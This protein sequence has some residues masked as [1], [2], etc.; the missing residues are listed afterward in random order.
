MVERTD[1]Q[2]KFLLKMALDNSVIASFQRGDIYHGAEGREDVGRELRER[3]RVFGAKYH[4]KVSDSKH[5]DNIA[6]L[7]TAMTERFAEDEFLFEG[8]FRIG[9]AQKALNLYLKYLWCLG[10]IPTP[11][12]CPID[13]GIL[14]K[15][16]GVP[17]ELSAWTKLDS[18]E[19][20]MTIIEKCREKA[21]VDGFKSI[22]EWELE[23]WTNG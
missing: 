20:Y 15:L 17:P 19:G 7:A 11:P 12:H 10:D 5:C 14:E 8:R 13:R 9:I 1:A 16:K 18:I 21:K 4:D 6:G 2:R 23:T 22:A 3:L